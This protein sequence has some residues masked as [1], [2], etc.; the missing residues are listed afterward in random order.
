MEEVG[1][2]ECFRQSRRGNFSFVSF[3]EEVNF[4]VTDSG[5]S[6]ISGVKNPKT[7]GMGVE[8]FRPD[9]STPRTTAGRKV[10]GKVIVGEVVW[11]REV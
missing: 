7:L 5:T 4:G 11:A 2:Y 8:G 10:R 3:V 6:L 1:R 9:V